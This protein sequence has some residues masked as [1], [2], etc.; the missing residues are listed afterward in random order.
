MKR[1]KLM[2]HL[3]RHGCVVLREGSRHTIVFNPVKNLQTS[4]ERHREINSRTT[5]GIC[6]QLDVPA[7]GEN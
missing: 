6:K 5:H 4:V 2:K 7:P 1:Q 3:R